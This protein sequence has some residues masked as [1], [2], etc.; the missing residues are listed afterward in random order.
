MA[1]VLIV[2]DDVFFTRLIKDLV[3]RMGHRPVTVNSGEAALERLPA[4]DPELLITDHLMHPMDGLELCRRVRELP[5]F[6]DLP[7]LMITARQGLDIW[8]KGAGLGVVAV[9]EKPFEFPELEARVRRLLAASA[10]ALPAPRAGRL[11]GDL[12]SLELTV[13]VQGLNLQRKTGCLTIEGSGDAPEVR[14]WFEKGEVHSVTSEER[15]TEEGKALLAGLSTRR[16]GAYVFEANTV[17]PP[18][19]NLRMNFFDVVLLLG[20]D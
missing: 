13:L 19:P 16:E 5:A 6:V 12:E 8:E 20:G 15:P 1:T 10:R 14:I 4:E 3:S 9:I 7:I 18:D 2:D 11:E 17:L